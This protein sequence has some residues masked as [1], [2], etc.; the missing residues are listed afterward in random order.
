MTDEKLKEF[1][2]HHKGLDTVT[3]QALGLA[4]E[5]KVLGCT[6]TAA[7]IPAPVVANMSYSNTT[8]KA[9]DKASFTVDV[10]TNVKFDLPPNAEI[11]LHTAKG[12]EPYTA[13]KVIPAGIEVS[14][15]IMQLGS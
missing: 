3:P 4:G 6:D 1:N 8:I 11:V 15:T 2:V 7:P 14:I 9:G 13:G 5:C 12:K 10:D